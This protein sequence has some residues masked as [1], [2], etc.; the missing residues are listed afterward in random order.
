MPTAKTEYGEMIETAKS[1][2]GEYVRSPEVEAMMQEAGLCP[3]CG[4]RQGVDERTR[5]VYIQRGAHGIPRFYVQC[6]MCGAKGPNSA[7]TPKE[8]VQ[9]WNGR[10][11]KTWTPLGDHTF[12]LTDPQPY[13][14]MMIMDDG[15]TVKFID[16]EGEEIHSEFTVKLGHFRISVQK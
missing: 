13:S 9:V 3:W 2:R 5:V 14:S 8:A 12:M 16:W 1:P 11:S 6:W 15:K 4:A 7:S 10:P